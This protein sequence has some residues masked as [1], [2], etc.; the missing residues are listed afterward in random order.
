MDSVASLR[1]HFPIPVIVCCFCAAVQTNLPSQCWFVNGRAWV[2]NS[3]TPHHSL[4]T[5]VQGRESFH[6][7]A[8]SVGGVAS[9]PA[10]HCQASPPPPSYLCEG[11]NTLALLDVWWRWVFGCLAFTI[12]YVSTR[13]QPGNFT[14]LLCGGKVKQTVG[15]KCIAFGLCLRVFVC[16]CSI[17]GPCVCKVILWG[18]ISALCMR[19]A[20][21]CSALRRSLALQPWHDLFSSSFHMVLLFQSGRC[22]L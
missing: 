10:L 16:S 11:S 17:W 20:Q 7:W 18:I 2:V 1:F 4:D 21:S 8:M 5:A 13:S 6:H 3:L 14:S 15:P 19:E 12:C 9:F 22:V